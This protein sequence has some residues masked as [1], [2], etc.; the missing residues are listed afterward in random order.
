MNSRKRNY[1]LLLIAAVAI[2]AT[3]AMTQAFAQSVDD[4]M[5][6]YVKGTS[7]IYTGNTHECWYDDGEGNMLP[8]RIDTGDTAWVLVATSFVLFMTPGLAFF[9]GGLARSK[10]AVNAIGMTFIVVGLI[11]VQWV[12]WGY[13]LAFGPNDTDANAYMGALEYAGYNHVSHYAPLGEP[14]PCGDTWSAAYQMNAMVDADQCGQGWPDTIPH[15]MFANFQAAF[16]IITPALIVGA[17]IDR[18]KF[19]ALV[20]FIVVWATFVYDPIA[21]WV[22]GGGFIGG[23]WIDLNPDLSP[24]FALDFAGGTVIHVTSG[25]AGLAG[26]M[27]LGRRLGYG[28]VPMEPHNIPLIVLGASILWFGWFGFNAGSELM[29]DGVAV[30]AWTVTNTATG[31]ASVT[32]MLM[33]WAHTG[34]PSIVGAA[35]G[36]VAGLVAITPA[37][38]FV[39]PMASIIIGIAAGTVCYGAVAFKNKRKWDDALDVWAVHGIGGLTGAILTGTLASPHVWDTGVGIGAWTGTPE[40]FEQQAINIIGAVMSMSY[41]FAATLVILKIMDAIWP[42]GIRVTPKEEEI[43]LDLA[44]HGERAYV[45]E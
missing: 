22:W 6:G 18:M 39:G 14:G 1:A 43:G 30:M 25:F 10:N 2:T 13:S 40:G 20:V 26:A 35:S 23:G 36:A 8:C 41:T 9:Y 24:S 3:S 38:G 31:M 19:S 4:G 27:V 21:H 17:Y 29:A 34:K 15:M 32:W 5:D 11:S 45:N 7:G 42:G 44:Q 37:S 16:A 33:S 12:L 28:K